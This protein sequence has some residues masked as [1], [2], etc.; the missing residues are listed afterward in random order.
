M[1]V[2]SFAECKET[3]CYAKSLFWFLFNALW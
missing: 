3:R 2:L 1:L